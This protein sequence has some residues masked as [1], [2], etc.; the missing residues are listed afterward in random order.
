MLIQRKCDHCGKLFEPTRSDKKYCDDKCKL[1]A[2]RERKAL[3]NVPSTTIPALKTNLTPPEAL[4]VS[5]KFVIDELTRQR[6]KLE[7][8][9]D[10]LISEAKALKERNAELEKERDKVQGDLEKK[11]SAL[12]GF[13]SDPK[14]LI[15]LGKEI[16]GMIAGIIE[17]CKQ[18]GGDAKQLNAP[19][20]QQEPII[21]WLVSQTPEF[22]QQFMD[23]VNGLA[24]NPHRSM[25]LITHFKRSL[26]SAGIKTGT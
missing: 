23:V 14:N 15:D 6:D 5:A 9:N 17:A 13:M 8:E 16:P 24:S 18:G 19:P 22:Q 7:K 26:M 25:E 3:G 1:D 2:F 12:A 11:P 21:K 20:A 4:P 10:L